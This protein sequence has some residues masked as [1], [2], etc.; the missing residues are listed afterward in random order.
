MYDYTTCGPAA[1][2][3]VLRLYGKSFR[4]DDVCRS[5]YVDDERR[6]SVRSICETLGRHGV[7]ARG[8]RLSIPE[9]LDRHTP[10]IVLSR[11]KRGGNHFLV[12]VGSE[13]DCV[14]LMDPL[15]QPFRRVSKDRLARYWRHEAIITQFSP[16]TEYPAKI[17]RM[18]NCL[19]CA[20]L[21]MLASAAGLTYA[22]GRR[23]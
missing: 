18:W 23:E 20:S 17:R 1:A 2:A 13:K 7:F 6:S 5:C 3:L 4:V 10:T 9:L 15:F 14:K 21:V 16:F 11:N 22:C 12:Y 19:M 8:C